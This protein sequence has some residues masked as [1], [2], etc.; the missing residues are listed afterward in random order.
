M[1]KRKNRSPYGLVLISFAAIILIGTVLLWLPWSNLPVEAMSGGSNLASEATPWNFDWG[2]RLINAFFSATSAVCVT[3]LSPYA[4]IAAQLTLFG[5]IVMMV[6][7]SL[8]GLGFISVFTFVV[9]A[10]GGHLGFIDRYI[11]K[12]ALSL[13]SIHGIIRFVRKM[14]LITLTFEVFGALIYATVFVPRFG[15]SEGILFS[16]FHSIS[17]FNNA[18]FDLLGST[19]FVAYANDPIININTMALIIFGGL[20]FPVII[21]LLRFKRIRNW[22]VYTKIVLFTTAVLVVGGAVILYGVEFGVSN[23]SV[24][25]ALFASVTARTAGFSTVDMNTVSL[26]G[27]MIICV[28][29]F[30]GASPLSTGGGI[31]TTTGFIVFLTIYSFI[32]GKHPHAFKRTFSN[33]T[34]VKAFSLTA[35]ALVAVLVGFVVIERLEVNRSELAAFDSTAYVFEAFSAFCTVGLSQGVTPLLTAGSKIVLILLM[36]LGRVGPMTTIAMFSDA[37]TRE[38]KKPFAYIEENLPIG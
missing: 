34:I 17:A 27:R 6:L 8:G 35:I 12:E 21:E 1:F 26:A 4:S 33:S 5:K 24:W 19:S 7:I 31:K 11:I 23:L 25:Q 36:F 2:T 30:I 29:M 16:V 15:W 9:T 3:G 10:V 13:D 20:G 37:M 22:S 28:L 32:S 14:L 18:G 38:N